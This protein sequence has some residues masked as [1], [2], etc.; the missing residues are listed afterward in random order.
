MGKFDGMLLLSDYDNTLRFTEAA[1]RQGG[2]LPPIAPRNLEAIRYWMAEGGR[3][4]VAT[5]RALNAFR[6]QAADIPMNAPSIVDNGAAIC[7][8]ARG[9]YLVRRF[10]PERALEHLTAVME[11]FPGVSLELYPEEGPV[12]VMHPTDWNH[13]H[14]QLTGLPFQ[15]VDAP[16]RRALPLAKALFIA[17]RPELEALRG[18]VA[19]RGWLEDYEMIFS[20]DHLLEM[21]ARGANKGDMALRLKALCGCGALICIGDHANDLPMLRAA[22]R[23][24][25]PAN[26]IREVL[27][28]GVEVVCHCL[29]GALAEVVAAVEAAV[30][31]GAGLRQGGQ[32]PVEQ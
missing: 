7:D 26:A 18:F 31:S 5:G 17:Q 20:S 9:E 14:A 1:L 28:S 29:D 12:L 23:A 21:T 10:L 25:A 2:L 6:Q 24:F 27:D 32:D 15:A 19:G 8:P 16:D 11:A 3:F 30:T 13:K 4:A 22:D